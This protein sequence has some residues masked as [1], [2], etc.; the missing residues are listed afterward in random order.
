MS[1]VWYNKNRA[2]AATSARHTITYAFLLQT[3]PSMREGSGSLLPDA[4]TASQTVLS[5]PGR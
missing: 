4:R 5:L 3:E 1:T 2:E